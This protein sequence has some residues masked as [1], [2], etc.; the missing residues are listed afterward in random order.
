M[1]TKHLQEAASLGRHLRSSTVVGA[2]RPGVGW[3]VWLLLLAIAGSSFAQAVDAPPTVAMPATATATTVT[4]ISTTLSVLGADD[5][6]EAAL[7][8]TWTTVGTPP[9]AVLFGANAGNAAKTVLATFTKIGTYTFQVTI[10]DAAGQTVQSTTAAIQVTPTFTSARITPATATILVGTSIQFTGDG[11]DQFGAPLA[12]QPNTRSWGQRSNTGG[13]GTLGGSTGLYTAHA[14]RTTTVLIQLTIGNFVGGLSTDAINVE[15]PLNTFLPGGNQPPTLVTPAV[16]SPALIPSG[17]PKTTVLSVLADDDGGESG[18]YYTWSI[19]ATP[20]LGTMFFSATNGSNAG[21]SVTATVNRAGRYVARVTITDG[22]NLSTFS[23]VEFHLSAT[24]NTAPFI[25]SLATATPNP[26]TGPTAQLAVLAGD[27]SGEENL[28]YTWTVNGT[29]PGTVSFSAN[30]TNGAKTN[31]ASFSAAGTYSLRATVTD[32]QGLNAA[33]DLS[34]I[35]T[36]PGNTPPTVVLAAS[37]PASPVVGTAVPV[38]VL[39]ADDGGEAALTYAWTVATPQPGPVHFSINGSNAAKSAVATFQNAGT[40]TL[41]ATMTDALGLTAVSSVT[42]TVGAVANTPPTVATAASAANNPLSGIQ[43]SLS[44]LG[45]D[46]GGQPALKYTWSVVGSAPGAVTFSPYN[47]TAST[48][49]TNAGRQMFA[50]FTVSGTYT[51]R[52]R[53][54]DA[55]GLFVNSDFNLVVNV[56]GTNAA[57]T[58]ATAATA[59]PNPVNGTTTALSVLGADDG[60]A[61]NLTYTWSV[62]GTPPG[63]VT[64]SP[65]GTNAAK[66]ATATFITSGV[67]TLLVTIADVPGRTVTSQVAVTVVVPGTTTAPTVATAAS[68]SP[69]PLTGTTTSLSVLGA[70]D[71]GE[72]ALTYTWSVVGTPPGAVTFA[73]NGTNAA[74]NTTATLIASGS[75]TLRVTITDAT[76]LS[77]TSTVTV[78]VP[79]PNAAP[80]VASAITATPSPVAGTTT[81]LSVLGADDGGEGA[82]TYAW[83][84]AGTPPGAV[85]FS[86]NGSNAAKTSTAT[87]TAIGTYTIVVTITDAQ[88]LTVMSSILVQVVA[89]G[90]NLAPTVATGAAATP[91]PLTGTTTVLSA[92]GADDGGEPALTYTWAVVGTAPGSVSFSANGTNAAK[93]TTATCSVGGIYTLRVTI[94]DAGGLTVTSTVTVTVPTLNAPPTVVTTATATPNP[95]TGTT[96][97]LA[98]LGADDAGEGA[99]TYTWSTSGT[100]PAPVTLTANG[101]NAAKNTTVTFTANGTYTFVV[102]IADAGGLTV[103][104]T[105]AVTVVGV[106][107][108]LPPTVATPA[109]ATPNPVTGTTSVLSVLGAD[110]AGEAGLTYAWATVGAVPGPVTFS[111]NGT[112]A[113]KSVTAT[114]S[115]VGTHVVAVTITD[116]GGLTVT[117]QVTVVVDQ[118]ATSVAVTPVVVSL[119][120]AAVQPFIATVRDQFG[121]ALAVQPAITW[122]LVPGGA[123]GSVSGTGVFTAP[124]AGTGTTQ[125]RATSAGLFGQ[126]MVTVTAA[127]GGGSSGGSDGGGGGGGGCGLGGAIGLV[128]CSLLLALRRRQ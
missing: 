115:T 126:S 21:K 29:A 5:G 117:S 123:G 86:P 82:L 81:V 47:G 61:A 94:T 109:V 58:V 122:S 78:T 22:F 97:V 114:F 27:D 65:N 110:D 96:T 28:T 89:G 9:A 87:F 72:P 25:V 49:G 75:Y 80:T 39:G 67:Y 116:A 128:G 16:A 124:A 74:K 17:G 93:A 99:L 4:G 23:E 12:V 42:V 68:A 84:T 50:Q 127:P 33:S 15:V 70:D 20:S 57:P 66:N 120:H 71:G 108:N 125:V 104:S 26:V 30:A 113:A 41:R 53:I 40:Y 7:T 3:A 64:F 32:Q 83:S 77:V 102:T 46:D 121:T 63:L 79:A 52:A 105:V 98:V 88:G 36:T 59:T 48:Q 38:S 18:L 92:L 35:V 2:R 107:G 6:G 54:E 91:N 73:A 106:A 90:A 56:T 1:T 24:A 119:A 19:S 85:T 14:T 31:T 43:A 69:N 95:V 62:V 100:P 45:A 10:R 76:G 51:L 111:S 13:L 118:H 60:G 11:L 112:N 101:S 34:V 44:V 8:Y 37:A 103:T 55:P